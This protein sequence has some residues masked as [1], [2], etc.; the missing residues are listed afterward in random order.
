MTSISN[1]QS[2]ILASLGSW[3][4]WSAGGAARWTPEAPSSSL[5]TNKAIMECEQAEPFA[6]TAVVGDRPVPVFGRPDVLDKPVE[7]LSAGQ[8]EVVARFISHSDGRV[9]LRLKADAGW[10]STRSVED[11]AECALSAVEEEASFEPEKFRTWPLKSPARDCLPA[12]EEAEVKEV[13]VKASEEAAAAS[14]EAAEE[15]DLD[16]GAASLPDDEPGGDEEPEEE[17]GEEGMEDVL[18]EEEPQPQG[19]AATSPSKGGVKRTTTRKF[20]ILSGRCSILSKPGAAQL[21]I[22]GQ[23]SLQKGETFL[24]DGVFWAPAEQRAYLRMTR[25]LGWICERSKT[26]LWRLAVARLTTRKAPVSKK[27]AKAVAFRG[28]D[29][30]G[31]IRLKQQDL[32][33]NRRGKIVSRRASEASKKKS[34]EGFRAW[35]AA[36]KRAR[37]ELGVSGFAVVKKGTPLYDKAQEIYKASSAPKQ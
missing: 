6:R 13:V 28:G 34:N 23:R 12:L 21:R 7:N 1:V 4:G 2:S 32:V 17:E 5:L 14:E 9:Y 8:V 26:D 19:E 3:R 24:A 35:T 31:V 36:V 22:P 25:G 29:T 16:D 18:D 37:D 11:L 10:V 30:G 33:K 15:S 20:R 27:M